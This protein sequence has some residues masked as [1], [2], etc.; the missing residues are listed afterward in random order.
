MTEQQ[1]SMLR[2][3]G[4]AYQKTVEISF[5]CGNCIL[6]KYSSRPQPE[7]PSRDCVICIYKHK[8]FSLNLNYVGKSDIFVPRFCTLIESTDD[9]T[10][11]GSNQ[12]TVA[13]Q[14]VVG[15]SSL[16]LASPFICPNSHPTIRYI[17]ISSRG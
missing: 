8:V 5:S 3:R 14:L 11:L 2:K 6:K 10:K 9:V 17:F 16:P 1:H 13:L 15:P 4:I 7:T 12:R